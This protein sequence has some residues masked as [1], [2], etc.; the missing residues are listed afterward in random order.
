MKSHAESFDASPELEAEGLLDKKLFDSGIWEFESKVLDI[1]NELILVQAKL[2]ET[3]L[4]EQPDLEVEVKNKIKT[5]EAQLLE[6]SEQLTSLYLALVPTLKT[7]KLLLSQLKQ[8]ITQD[9]LLGKELLSREQRL[10]IMEAINKIR[11]FA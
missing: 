7:E 6:G 8:R 10:D 1:K 9:G 4:L 3:Q 2:L 11:G 5:L